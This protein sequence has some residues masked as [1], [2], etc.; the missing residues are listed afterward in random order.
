MLAPGMWESALELPGE[1]LRPQESTMTSS[2]PPPSS[3]CVYEGEAL[4]MV[5][6]EA[7]QVDSGCVGTNPAEA[8]EKDNKGRQEDHRQ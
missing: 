1:G 4:L 2:R 5:E 3:R 8:E 7:K 6:L